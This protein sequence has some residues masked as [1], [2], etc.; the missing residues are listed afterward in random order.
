VQAGLR[1]SGTHI[2]RA[3]KHKGKCFSWENIGEEAIRELRVSQLESSRAKRSE[4][5]KKNWKLR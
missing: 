2:I 3:G 5:V 1:E 4:A